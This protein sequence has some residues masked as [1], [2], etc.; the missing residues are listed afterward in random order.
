M[1]EECDIDHNG[2]LDKNEMARTKGYVFGMMLKTEAFEGVARTTHDMTKLSVK[3]SGEHQINNH[4]DGFLFVMQREGLQALSVLTSI[5]LTML[6][7]FCLGLWI[8]K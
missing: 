6:Y 4:D 8:C 7:A 5:F 1:L 3:F 2:K